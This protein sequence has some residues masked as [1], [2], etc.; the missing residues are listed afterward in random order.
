MHEAKRNELEKLKEKI[1]AD[2]AKISANE[3]KLS[4]N[5]QEAQKK[6]NDTKVRLKKAQKSAEA[7][8]ELKN[9][10]RYAAQRRVIDEIKNEEIKLI[11]QKCILNCIKDTTSILLFD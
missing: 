1:D 4:A 11:T 8:V 2:I 5:R 9:L 6:I 3:E 7:E 10:E